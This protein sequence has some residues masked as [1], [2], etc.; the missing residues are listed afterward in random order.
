MSHY[1]SVF[2]VQG[3]QPCLPILN[4][5]LS[6]TTNTVGMKTAF[7]NFEGGCYAKVI[8]LSQENEPEIWNAIRRNA[9]LENVVVKNDGSIDFTDASLTENTRVSYPIYH[10]DNI[11]TPSRAGHAS[12]IIYLSPMLMAYYLLFP[13]WMKKELN[14]IL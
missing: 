13:Y 4:V 2:P 8:N 12:R 1:F 14:I 3:K 6:E 5:Y 7:S 9:L 11:V 10:I